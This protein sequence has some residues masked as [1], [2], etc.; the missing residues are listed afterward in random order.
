VSDRPTYPERYNALLD[1][2]EKETIKAIRHFCTGKPYLAFSGGKDS[3]VLEKLARMAAEALDGMEYKIVRS[4]SAGVVA[5]SHGEENGMQDIEVKNRRTGDIIISG[6]Y[7]SI[8]DCL[9]RNRGRNLWRAYL[10]GANLS[11]ADLS[12]A[13]LSVADL[14]EAFLLG[15]DLSEAFLLGAELSGA[16]LSEAYLSRAN[17]SGAYLSVADLS[18]ADLSG[19]D[20]SGANLWRAYLSGANLSE[21]YLSGANLSGAY[22]SGAD[23]S[24]ADL[25]RAFLLG[26]DLSGAYLSGANLSGAN[27]WRANLS[28]AIS[29]EFHNQSLVVFDEQKIKCKR[30]RFTPDLD[31]ERRFWLDALSRVPDISC[32]TSVITDRD[33]CWKDILASAK[34]HRNQLLAY[35]HYLPAVRQAIDIMTRG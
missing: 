25:S 17:L 6:K 1:D 32:L 18:G 5:L 4:Y 10:S 23:L 24:G 16:N 28:G 22:L 3:V 9:E 12:G 34:K 21:A 14:S 30:V 11:G 35:E 2:L 13:D 20:L 31:A 29:E 27:L 19:A 15:A 7:E 33:K 26:A 8:K